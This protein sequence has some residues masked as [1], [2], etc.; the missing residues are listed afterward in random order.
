MS[1]SNINN[2]W[3][4]DIPLPWTILE[5]AEARELAQD[6]LN[7]FFDKFPE[8]NFDQAKEITK[9]VF[10]AIGEEPPKRGPALES[11]LKKYFDDVGFTGSFPGSF[12]E[13][14]K[15][16]YSQIGEFVAGEDLS[17]IHI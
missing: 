8:Y 17:L 9:G 2:D 13:R 3:G 4:G 6:A 1:K 7:N 14:A 10:D 16:I 11:R 5:F 12:E 15:L